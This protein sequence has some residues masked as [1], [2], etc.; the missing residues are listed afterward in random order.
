LQWK[1]ASQVIFFAGLLAGTMDITAAFITWGIQGVPP[2]VIL[3]GIA[4]GLLGMNAFRGGMEM[5]ALGLAIHFFI[6]FCAAG[7][8][9]A[10]SRK[11]GFMLRRPILSGVLYG[12]A[13]YVF[14]YW[15]V[16]PL[17]RDLRPPFSISRSIVAVLTHIVCIGLPISLIVRRYSS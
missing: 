12:V 1:S 4:S 15:V 5:A 3:R 11:L 7:V 17:S 10:A 16:L 6:A 8:F 9:Y 2:V 13:V 14:M